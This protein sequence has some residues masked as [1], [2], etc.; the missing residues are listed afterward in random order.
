MGCSTTRIA[1]ISNQR[2]SHLQPEKMAR[3]HEA[4]NQDCKTWREHHRKHCINTSLCMTH[5]VMH[6]DSKLSVQL[7]SH[8]LHDLECVL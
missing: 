5:S 3:E 4:S 7:Y 2:Q 8:N 6:W 1:V